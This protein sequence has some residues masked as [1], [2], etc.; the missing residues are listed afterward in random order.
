M[1]GRYLLQNLNFISISHTLY[2]GLGVAMMVT[3]K[4][5]LQYQRIINNPVPVRAHLEHKRITVQEIMKHK[6]SKRMHRQ[7][8][9]EKIKIRAQEAKR[10]VAT[11]LKD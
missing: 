1:E 3:Y 8:K 4:S 2:L 11:A 5:K 6:N 7:R 10:C 9:E